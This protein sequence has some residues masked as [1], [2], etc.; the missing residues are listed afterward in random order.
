MRSQTYDNKTKETI[1]QE[2]G[3]RKTLEELIKLIFTFARV[4]VL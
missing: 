1:E 4:G 3:V 2:N